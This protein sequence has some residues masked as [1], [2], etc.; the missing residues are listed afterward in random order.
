MDHTDEQREEIETLKAIFLEEFSEISLYPPC[1][2]IRLDDLDIALPSPVYLKLT[3]PSRYPEVVPEIQIPNRSKSLPQGVVEELLRFLLGVA[4]DSCG[5]VMIFSIVNA[6]K[7]W[8]NENTDKIEKCEAQLDGP[9]NE[10]TDFS[11]QLSSASII[12]TEERS[13]YP[14]GVGHGGIWKFVI[15]LIGKLLLHSRKVG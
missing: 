11:N 10:V 2:M 4:E 7:E 14:Q 15:G 13:V 8:I 5:M 6:A 12:A 9:A 1:F 3:L